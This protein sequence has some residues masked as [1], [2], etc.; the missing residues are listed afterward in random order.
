MRHPQTKQACCSECRNPFNHI[1]ISL[2]ETGCL[3]A[4]LQS[5]SVQDK[6][7][8]AYGPQLVAAA[9]SSFDMPRPLQH[10]GR[11]AAIAPYFNN[12]W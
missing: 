1:E 8:E 10:L 5:S 12:R 4:Q 2:F 3:N 6:D 7:G 11:T 9:M